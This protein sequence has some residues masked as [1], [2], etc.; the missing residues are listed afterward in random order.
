[1]TCDAFD[2]RND[3]T[4]RSHIEVH[5]R[6]DPRSAPQRKSPADGGAFSRKRR[7]L[8]R[9][10]FALDFHFHA[11]VRREAGDQL[12]HV[13]LIADHARNRLRLAHAQRLD[14]ILRHAAA[15]QVVAHRVGTTL[16]QTLVVL[17]RADAVGVAG[18][19]HQLELR[20]ARQLRD[21]VV[22][23]RRTTVGPQHGLVEVEQRLAGQRDLLHGRGRG[24]LRR[25]GPGQVPGQAQARVPGQV[26]GRAAPAA[27]ASAS[28]PDR[29]RRSPSPAT[30]TR[31]ASTGR[32]G[33]RGRRCRR[34]FSRRCCRASR[35]R[36]AHSAQFVGLH[37][38]TPGR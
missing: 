38:A 31:S 13:L 21:H 5:P 23:D 12:L 9:D 36:R 25:Q 28:D 14:A 24:R 16:G 17:L 7:T 22:V 1:M 35:S 11:A 27:P 4:R 29:S 34:R 3:C 30:R 2:P 33:G 37:P 8:T 20:N 10:A 19:Q 26:P 6:P 18:D 15:D 32:P